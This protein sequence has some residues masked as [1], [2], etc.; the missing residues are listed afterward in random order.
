M[1]LRAVY[2]DMSKLK[3]YLRSHALR[4]VLFYEPGQARNGAALS[5]VIYALRIHGGEKV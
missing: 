4:D 1:S 3:L 5:S 2:G